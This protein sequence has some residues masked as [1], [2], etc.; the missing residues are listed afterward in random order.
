MTRLQE[1]CANLWIYELETPSFVVRAAVVLGEE[2]AVV[3]DTLS[4]P[5]EAAPLV[6]VLDGK[7]YYVVYSHGDY[8]H[9]W[10]TAG[11]GEKRLAV[12]AHAECLRRFGDDVPRALQRMQMAEPSQWDNVRLIPPNIT[13]ASCL[14]LDLGGLTLELHHCPGHTADSLVGWIPER[15]LLLGGDAIETPLPVVND[16]QLLPGWLDAL[17]AWQANDRLDYA[18]PSHGS[19]T[20]RESLDQTVA[21]LRALAGDRQFMLPRKLEGF[22]RETHQKNLLAVDSGRALHE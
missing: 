17:T 12:V 15:G 18:I 2:R 1:F 16:A 11:L 14:S 10:G 19:A 4:L 8:D 3:W 7:P 22:Y 5:E 9:A 21:Y 20:G 13:F 6:D